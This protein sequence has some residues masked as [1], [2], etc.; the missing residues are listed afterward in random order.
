[1]HDEAALEKRKEL[2][3]AFYEKRF[4]TKEERHGAKYYAVAPEQNIGE[5][6]IQELFRRNGVG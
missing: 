1:M 2:L 6:E 5:T 4:G 3:E